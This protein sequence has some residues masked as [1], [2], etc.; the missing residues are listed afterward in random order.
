V[1]SQCAQAY[2]SSEPD[3]DTARVDAIAYYLENLKTPRPPPPDRGAAL[4][5]RIGCGGCHRSGYPVGDELAVD[6]YSD[7]LLH[8]MG[9]ALADGSR[10][11]GAGPRE[12]RTA[13]LWGIGLA[14][15]LNPQ[16][17]FLHDGRAATPELAILW[18]AGEA[19]AARVKFASLDAA[20]RAAI[21]QFLESL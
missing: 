14:R 5:A 9:E 16:A 3:V 13:P 18:H 20:E 4:F 1:Q 8:D 17:G 6:P 15:R 12:W 10:V 2:A 21:L 11:Y 7:F 19:R